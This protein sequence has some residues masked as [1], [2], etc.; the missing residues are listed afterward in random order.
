MSKRWLYL[1]LGLAIAASLFAV[2][3][4]AVESASLPALLGPGMAAL[5]SLAAL[6]G[7]VR[8][9]PP[10]P[11]SLSGSAGASPSLP[12]NGDPLDNGA[13]LGLVQECVQ[14]VDELDRDSARFDPPRLEVADHVLCRL[15]EAL[16]RS[17]V[18]SIT[19]EPAFDRARHQ[20]TGATSAV[21]GAAIAETLSPG[22]AVGKRIL[23]R[24][25]VRIGK[26][27]S[28]GAVS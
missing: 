6:L 10:Q 28:P 7:L 19:G 9:A 3:H 14:M 22:F 18:E 11:P 1:S 21:P 26:N 25:R 20:A 16:E 12:S 5:A 23:R 24:A 2:I 4:A 13:W 17:G 8:G 27:D 15:R